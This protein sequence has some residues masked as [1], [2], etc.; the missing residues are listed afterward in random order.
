[1]QGMEVAGGISGRCLSRV[2]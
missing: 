1:M 2:E